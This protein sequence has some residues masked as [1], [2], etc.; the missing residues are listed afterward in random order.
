[1][2]CFT[3]E[4]ARTLLKDRLDGDGLPPRGFA[5]KPV[6]RFSFSG[7]PISHLVSVSAAVI[8]TV[9]PWEQAWWWVDNPDTWNRPLLPLYYHVR[10]AA[11]DFRLITEAPIHCFDLHERSELLA[12]VV[13]TLLNEW[14]AFLMTSHD[15][16]RVLVTAGHRLT[17][18]RSDEVE[19]ESIRRKLLG[20]GFIEVA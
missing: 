7:H 12:L 17:V 6:G 4:E 20:D 5:N 15:Y 1:M 10:H 14:N 19:F 18:A 2:R 13:V 9:G 8:E 16:G 3:A 11:H